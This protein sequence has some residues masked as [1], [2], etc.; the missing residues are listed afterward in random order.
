L[1]LTLSALFLEFLFHS[2]SWTPSFLFL[3]VLFI[4][5]EWRDQVGAMAGFL[6][7]VFYAGLFA[8]PLGLSAL[9]LTLV[10]YLAGKTSPFLMDTPGIV[11]FLFAF[12]I[13]ILNDFFGSA[14]MSFF[15]NPFWGIRMGDALFG[16][17]VFSFMYNPLH[18]IFSNKR[19]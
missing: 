13:F 16:G 7:G 4:A 19:M 18:R 6:V 15:Y 14:V 1:I 9:T 17:L 10:G 11:L 5:L 12:I 3:V 2:Y 8:E